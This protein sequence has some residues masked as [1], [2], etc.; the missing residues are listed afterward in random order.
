MNIVP[1]WLDQETN[2]YQLIPNVE[3]DISIRPR[4]YQ[5]IHDPE[6]CVSDLKSSEKYYECYRNHVQESIYSKEI[7]KKFCTKEEF[8]NCTIP[9]VGKIKHNYFLLDNIS[10]LISVRFLWFIRR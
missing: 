4:E 3:V 10:F 8:G 6:K 1:M 9:H 2:Y 7:S 5:R